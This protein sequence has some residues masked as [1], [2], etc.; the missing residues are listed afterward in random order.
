MEYRVL[1]QTP[2]GQGLLERSR[3][4]WEDNILADLKSY[5]MDRIGLTQGWDK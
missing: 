2:E 1:V 3:R 4:R 5:A